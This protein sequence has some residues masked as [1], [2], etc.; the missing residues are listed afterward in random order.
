L[1]CSMILRKIYLK[2]RIIKFW[3]YFRTKNN[4]MMNMKNHFKMI[5]CLKI[6]KHKLRKKRKNLNM[7]NN[8]MKKLYNKNTKIIS[9][10]NV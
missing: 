2:I 5:A 6:K 7:L 1:S 8:Q 9:P 4:L 10:N 3:H